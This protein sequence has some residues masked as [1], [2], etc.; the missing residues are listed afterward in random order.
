LPKEGNEEIVK[1]YDNKFPKLA[2]KGPDT[3]ILGRAL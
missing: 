3:I 1:K 2:G